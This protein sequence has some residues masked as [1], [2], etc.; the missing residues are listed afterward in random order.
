MEINTQNKTRSL[1]LSSLYKVTGE[2]DHNNQ[3][4]Q[5]KYHMEEAQSQI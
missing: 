4:N 1:F 3:S 5:I 2:I